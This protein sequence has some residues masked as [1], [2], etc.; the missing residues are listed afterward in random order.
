MT[1]EFSAY[2]RSIGG[3]SYTDV[4]QGA[5]TL[6][7][8]G[9]FT[10]GRLWRH[11]IDLPGH[12]HTR[13]NGEASAWGLADAAGTVI[14][15]LNLRDIPIVAAVDIAMIDFAANTSIGRKTFPN[16]ALSGSCPSTLA[17]QMPRS[18]CY[19]TSGKPTAVR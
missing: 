4:G 1:D 11:C 8:H 2:R 18:A 3:F 15:Q 9:V 7:V 12:G 6:F 13:P 14:D 16:A 10:N 19:G 17:T 5:V